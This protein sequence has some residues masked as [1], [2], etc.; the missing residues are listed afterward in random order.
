MHKIHPPIPEQFSELAK[1]FIKSCFHPDPSERP[2]SA[3]LLSHPFIKQYSSHS[4]RSSASKKRIE[5]SDKPHSKFL[6]SA[7][8]M[9]GMTLNAAA[10]ISN[11]AAPLTAGTVKIGRSQENAQSI[12]ERILVQPRCKPFEKSSRNNEKNLRLRIEPTNLPIVTASPRRKTT[13][14]FKKFSFLAIQQT[15]QPVSASPK[16]IQSNLI[17][18]STSPYEPQAKRPSFS[19]KNSPNPPMANSSAIQIP[20]P[21]RF[22]KFNKFL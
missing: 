12:S 2:S 20:Q 7:S 19:T 10:P 6:R 13:I 11:E 17:S 18:P 3:A 4:T 1:G 16:L 22:M 5:S 9:S 14:V 8:H 15:L 21:L